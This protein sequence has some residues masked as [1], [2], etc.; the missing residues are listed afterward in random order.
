MIIFIKYS[1]QFEGKV[2]TMRRGRPAKRDIDK[3]DHQIIVELQ[4]DGR[5]SLVA[6]GNKV[7]LKHSSVRE[8]LLRLIKE[9]TIKVQANISLK[10]LGYS[11]AFVG[12]EAENIGKTLEDISRFEGCPRV[13]I[14]G[15]GS[16][17]YNLFL[18]LVAKDFNT[19]RAFIE[20]N[21]RSLS[22]IRRI[23]TSFGDIIH[24]SFVPLPLEPKDIMCKPECD[25]CEM[26][27][28]LKLCTGCPLV[29]A[30]D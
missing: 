9:R 21:I 28:L 4:E 17:D 2:I 12:I 18:I 19:L 20:K 7:G 23:S 5:M 29:I 10:K 30:L 11:A 3:I 13:L 22:G 15:T 1:L 16:G 25:T 26:Y 24:P 8:R 27:A 6:L 14:I